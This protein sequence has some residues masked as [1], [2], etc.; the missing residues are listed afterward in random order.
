ML[1]TDCCE[2]TKIYKITVF[3]TKN[4]LLKSH[5]QQNSIIS[6]SIFLSHEIRKL[7]ERLI[8]PS[9]P[10]ELSKVIYQIQKETL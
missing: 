10:L 3:S 8:P 4:F 1:F 7:R 9:A 5:S 2:T 6:S